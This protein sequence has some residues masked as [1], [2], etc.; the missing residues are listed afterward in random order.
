MNLLNLHDY[1]TAAESRLPR[2][3]YD[4]FAG[5]ANDE[6]TLVAN[7]EAWERVALHYRVLRDVSKRSL[8]TTVLGTPM[9]MPVAIAPMAFHKLAHPEGEV[10][11]AKAAAAAGVPFSLST[12]ATTAI[13]QVRAAS[14]GPIWFQL[15]VHTD[16]GVTRDLVARA[17]AAGCTA[18]VLT[19]DVA[20][21]GR[22]ERD[23]RNAFVLPPEV[24]I[25]HAMPGQGMLNEAVDGSALAAFVNG[26]LDPS[27]TW[28]D[29]EWLRSVTKL[30][31]AVKGIVRA[32][33]AHRA[34]EC[35]AAA[36]V[37]SNH[38]GRQLDGAPATAVVLPSVVDRIGGAAEVLVDGGIRRGVDVVRAL[39]L[40]ARAVLVGRPVLWGLAVDGERGVSGVLG[41][42]RDEMDTAMALC[43]A[44]T[45][46]AVGRDLI[47]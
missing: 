19:V 16:R 42:L 21:M 41:L 11:T 6:R 25:A 8:A 35:G 14:A 20:A 46:D 5:G 29:V 44:T 1:A 36:V 9:A 18:L 15:Y 39:A 23:I 27:L 30:P 32:D 43:G 37:V 34:V 22:R 3:V 10:G 38:G 12:L 40:G 33:D 7:R 28:R 47:A 13:E 4:Y 24:R 2:G 17:E 26:M 45:V 31:L